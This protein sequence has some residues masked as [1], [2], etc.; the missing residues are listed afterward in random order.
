M[1][2]YDSPLN[3]V[4]RERVGNGWRGKKKEIRRGGFGWHAVL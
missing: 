3:S 1:N 4:E 2:A